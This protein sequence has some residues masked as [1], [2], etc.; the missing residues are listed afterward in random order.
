M[1]YV[2]GHWIICCV[3]PKKYLE[4]FLINHF[5]ASDKSKIKDEIRAEI[6][7]E[8]HDSYWITKLTKKG[9]L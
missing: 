7:D 5:R 6:S 1:I 3:P 9:V 8:R 4:F 2:H